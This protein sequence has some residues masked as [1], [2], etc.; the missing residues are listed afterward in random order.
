MLTLS[1][2][3]LSVT[4]KSNMLNGVRLNVV[5]LNVVAPRCCYQEDKRPEIIFTKLFTVINIAV[6]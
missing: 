5:T 4:I 1:V 2:I 3:L 6:S